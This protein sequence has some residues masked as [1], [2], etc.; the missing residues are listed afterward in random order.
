MPEYPVPPTPTPT[1]TSTPTAT[2]TLAPPAAVNN[3]T[4]APEICVPIAPPP[5][6]QYGGTLTWED[7]SDNESGF[8]IYLNGGLF[9]STAANVTSHPLP[10]LPFNMGTP[11]TWGVEAFNS[12]GK[13]AIK[14]VVMTCP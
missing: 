10:L 2:A 5:L 11:L 7:K 9:H 3:V 8:N 1:K 12:A 4:V 14:I 6:Y 13:A